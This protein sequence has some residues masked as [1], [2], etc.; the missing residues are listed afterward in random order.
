MIIKDG[1]GGGY[2]ALVDKNNRLH[3][4][5]VAREVLTEAVF[6]GDGYN[7]NTGEMTLTS[8][9]ES[10]VGYFNYTGDSPFVITEIIF[11]VGST[12]GGSGQG[13]AKIYRNPTGGTIVDNAVP[14]DVS[15]NRDF[16][17]SKTIDGLI[18]KGA[19]GYTTTGGTIFADSTRTSF[20]AVITFDAAPVI[21]R[22]GNSLSVSWTPPAGNTSQT[23][24]IAATGYMSTSDVFA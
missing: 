6:Q 13:E 1:A 3:T 23:V 11:I 21:L 9:N 12:A 24:K 4:E 7:F 19:E 18:Y 20:G 5:S 16:S 22:K 8:A 10:A 14:I 15:A 17:S 2:G